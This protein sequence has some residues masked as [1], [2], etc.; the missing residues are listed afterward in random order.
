MQKPQ[1][2]LKKKNLR[3][4]FS[5]KMVFVLGVQLAFFKIDASLFWNILKTY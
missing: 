3:V 4:Y 5:T 1:P 2:Y